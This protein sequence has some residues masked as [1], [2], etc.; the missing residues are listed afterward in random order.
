MDD[1]VL[2]KFLEG[3][4]DTRGDLFRFGNGN[5]TPIA[6]RFNM[7]LQIAA[8]GELGN[9]CDV[10][11]VPNEIE[12]LKD[13]CRINPHQLVVD[14]HF[15]FKSSLVGRVSADALQEYA[16]AGFA[17]PGHVGFGHSTRVQAAQQVRR[18]PGSRRP[19]PSAAV[20]DH[21][22]WRW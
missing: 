18:S 20:A 10:L 1:V 3:G 22:G 19:V 15:A 7:S 4:G 9:E 5:T 17:I 16:L 21:G 6:S 12:N 2:M 11:I 8:I 13:V 14:A